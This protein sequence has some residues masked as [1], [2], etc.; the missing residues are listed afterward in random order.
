[1]RR[2]GEARRAGNLAHGRVG[3]WRDE[4]DVSLPAGRAASGCPGY[5]RQPLQ[6]STHPSEFATRG[7][8][9][10][11]TSTPVFSEPAAGRTKS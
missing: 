5:S 3:G 11:V 8:W 1:M 2:E 7:S 6:T 10:M 4:W 9:S